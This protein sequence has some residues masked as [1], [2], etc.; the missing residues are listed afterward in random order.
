LIQGLASVSLW[1]AYTEAAARK[2][3]AWIR[4]VFKKTLKWNL[5]IAI[6]LVIV[7]TIFGRT[8]IQFWAGPAAVPPFAVVIWMGV[9]GIMLSYL[10]VVACLLNATGKVTRMSVY[11]VI[12]AILN[13][14]LSIWLVRLYGISGVI[15]ATV[16]AYTI[17][18]CI[19]ILI[20]VRAVLAEFSLFSDAQQVATDNA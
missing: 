10:Q 20:D 9:W 7:L 1:P 5:L 6:G 17:A 11:G 15:A 18:S 19:P 12:T 16:I 4:G 2:D 14:I 13:V 8:I 3:F